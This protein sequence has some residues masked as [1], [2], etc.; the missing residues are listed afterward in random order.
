LIRVNQEL[1]HLAAQ[2]LGF[3]GREVRRHLLDQAEES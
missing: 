2:C 1:A 3:A